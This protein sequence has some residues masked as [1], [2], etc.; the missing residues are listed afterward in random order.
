MFSTKDFKLIDQK[1]YKIIRQSEYD[2]ELMSLSTNHYWLIRFNSP[3]LILFH[4]Y[5]ASLKYH[6]QA[7][8]NPIRLIYVLKYIS[9]HDNNVLLS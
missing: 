3:D 1:R 8:Y 9:K 2:I 4:K 7:L 6:R 5:N